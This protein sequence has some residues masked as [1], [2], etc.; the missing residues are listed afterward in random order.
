MPQG[1]DYEQQQKEGYK[2][3]NTCS[4]ILYNTPPPFFFVAKIESNPFDV[5]NIYQHIRIL[6]NF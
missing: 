4:S 3:Y 5:S 2:Y 6:N 1:F